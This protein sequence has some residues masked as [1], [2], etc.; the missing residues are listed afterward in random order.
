VYCAQKVGAHPEEWDFGIIGLLQLVVPVV[1]S[2]LFGDHVMVVVLRL[3][4]LRTSSRLHPGHNRLLA[5]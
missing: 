5:N 4:R 3:Q 1:E 2:V